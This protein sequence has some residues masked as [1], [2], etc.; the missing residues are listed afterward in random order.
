MGTHFKD[1]TPP[2][3][4][5]PRNWKSDENWPRYGLSNN[6]FKKILSSFC[7]YYWHK[8]VK[9]YFNSNSFW[10]SL[11]IYWIHIMSI[12]YKNQQKILRFIGKNPM[13]IDKNP[14]ISNHDF[15][16]VKL[17]KSVSSPSIFVLAIWD[18][19]SRYIGLFLC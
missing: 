9:N 15:P 12:F 8:I 3:K 1:L 18:F 5:V 13:K 4:T 2:I 14:I 10:E 17:T 11:D 16:R 7:N 19:M 6:F